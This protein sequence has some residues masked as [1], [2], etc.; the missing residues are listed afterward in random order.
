MNILSLKLV[1]ISYSG[2]SI[3]DDIRVEIE[4]LGAFFALNKKLQK[5]QTAD[6]QKE[7]VQIPVV[8]LSHVIPIF[9]RIIE[10]DPIFND[11]GSTE[12][13]ISVKSGQRPK[14]TTHHV[15]VQEWRGIL[16]R[17]ALFTVVLE[18][19][20][21]P[22]VKYVLEGKNGWTEVKPEDGK[23]VFS[24]PVHTKVM[25]SQRDDRR[26]YFTVMEGPERGRKASLTANR[27]GSPY[28]GDEN[29][30]S[31]PVNLIYSISKKTLRLDREIYQTVDYKNMPWAP[32]R[33]D[34]E[35]PDFSHRGGRVYL[36]EAPHAL[37]WF[38]VGHTDAR[39][40]HTGSRSAGCITLIEHNRWE[41]LYQILIRARK[42]D[43]INIGTLEVIV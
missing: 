10:R 23:K 30:H 34:V 43:G 17:K 31:A 9:L 39:Y 37:T 4:A 20:I 33:Y 5:G 27:D 8:E 7:V 19:V 2:Q 3:G 6:I 18:T 38:R 41:K 29:Q 14:Q 13:T 24:L 21:A 26:E 15:T 25:L 36:N 1:S 16:G 11:T 42:D 40:I 28:L 22:A 12:S 32:G 35:L